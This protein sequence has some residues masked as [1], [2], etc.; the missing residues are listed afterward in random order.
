M[1]SREIGKCVYTHIHTHLCIHPY[2]LYQ[3][4]A[5]LIIKDFYNS[6]HMNLRRQHSALILLS[7]HEDFYFSLLIS[8]LYVH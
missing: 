7:R 6:N 1:L 3:Q 4:D 8:E 2:A 5:V